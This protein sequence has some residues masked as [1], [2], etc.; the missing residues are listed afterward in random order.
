MTRMT[1]PSLIFNKS[2][3]CNVTCT[4]KDQNIKSKLEKKHTSVLLE[5]FPVPMF[6]NPKKY[7]LRLYLSLLTN[8]DERILSYAFVEKQE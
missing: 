3:V 5:A 8:Y 6:S 1:F 4:N 7:L 2:I